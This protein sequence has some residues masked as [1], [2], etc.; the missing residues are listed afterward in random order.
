VY[1]QNTVVSKSFGILADRPECYVYSPALGCVITGIP[2]HDVA[3]HYSARATLAEIAAG[4]GRVVGARAGDDLIAIIARITQA[5]WGELFGIT[6][7]FLVGCFTARSDIDLVCYGKRGY[8]AAAELFADTSVIAPYAGASSP[9]CICA[10]PSTWSATPSTPCSRP[11]PAR[12][13][14]RRRR[15]PRQLRAAALGRAGGALAT[16]QR[17][18]PIRRRVLHSR[19]RLACLPRSPSWATNAC[20]PRRAGSRNTSVSKR[21]GRSGWDTAETS[22]RNERPITSRRG[23]CSIR[24]RRGLPVTWRPGGDGHKP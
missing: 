23:S 13:P 18:R 12:G 15:C 21:K 10:A 7:S 6:G 9:N 8:D 1:R 24:S 2:R 20:R 14:H 3:T 19:A 11:R 17:C 16:P 22:A 5:G 4:P